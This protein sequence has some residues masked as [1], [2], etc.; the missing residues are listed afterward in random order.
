MC[1]RKPIS[2]LSQPNTFLRSDVQFGWPPPASASVHDSAVSSSNNCSLEGQELPVSRMETPILVPNLPDPALHLRALSSSNEQCWRLTYRPCSIGAP[3][4]Q[5]PP[6]CTSSHLQFQP[7]LH[8]SVASSSASRTQ[9]ICGVLHPVSSS[10]NP[11]TCE[12][13]L[14]CRLTA[15][16][17]V[18]STLILQP[19]TPTGSIVRDK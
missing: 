8:I 18:A 15:S 6:Y 17:Q 9:R 5:P 11:P 4:I 19:Q 7:I 10:D 12:N 2:P 1:T 14:G 3:G 16:L 13:S